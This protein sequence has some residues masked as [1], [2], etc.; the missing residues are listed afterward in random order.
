MKN[1]FSLGDQKTFLQTVTEAD[2]AAFDAGLVHPVYA[3]FALARD[4]EWS[5]RLFVLEMKEAGEEGIGT[6]LEIKHLSPALLG[7][8]VL[9]RATLEGVHGNEVVTRFTAHAGERLIATGRQWQ[10]IV[11]VEKLEKIFAAAAGK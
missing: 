11:A 3:T 7:S 2:V 6:G 1:P 4:A 8:H 5:G 10:R 9:F